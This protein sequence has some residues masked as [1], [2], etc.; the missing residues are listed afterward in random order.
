[1]VWTTCEVQICTSVPGSS[2]VC[3]GV[4]AHVLLHTRPG[5][6]LL[7]FAPSRAT[8]RLLCKDWSRKAALV[9]GIIQPLLP[10]PALCSCPWVWAPWHRIQSIQL[11]CEIQM[12][13]ALAARS[14]P[15]ALPKHA[16][17]PFPTCFNKTTLGVL[18]NQRKKTG[19]PCRKEASTPI[20]SAGAVR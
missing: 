6:T 5:L 20:H 3:I 17:T 15:C 19:L 9:C 4:P 12:P 8:T 10:S 18:V 2:G 1:M 16:Y 7:Q 11:Q 13:A 14:H